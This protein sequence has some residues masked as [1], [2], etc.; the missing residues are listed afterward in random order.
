[1]DKNT[2]SITILQAIPATLLEATSSLSENLMQSQVF[3]RYRA[4][5]GRLHADPE[6][7]Q[8]LT[9]LADAQQKI[10]QQQ[11]S[12]AISQVDLQQLRVLQV[13]VKANETIQDHAMCQ[14][15]A[16]SFLR[17]VNQEISSLLGFDFASL[18]RRSDGCC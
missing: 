16:K 4:A 13:A 14:E 1:M 15:I 18:A 10:R 11:Y 6:A 17:E 2:E 8:L 5:D 7:M 9:D 3:Q 12:G